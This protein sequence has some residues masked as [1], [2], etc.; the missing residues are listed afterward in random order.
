MTPNNVKELIESRLAGSQAQVEGDGRHFN[1]IV[2]YDGF[3]GKTM[4]E[5][6]KMVYEA[7][8]EDMKNIHALSMKTFTSEGWRGQAQQ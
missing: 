8:G 6:H 7:L 3:A 2:I 5:Q 1:A 4:L